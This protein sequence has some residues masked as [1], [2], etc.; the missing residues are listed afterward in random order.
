[1]FP[2]TRKLK[3]L[4]SHPK[5]AFFKYKT[6]AYFKIINAPGPYID[7]DYNR[8]WGFANF[9]GKKILDLGADY[10]STAWFFIKKGANSVVA[11][12]GDTSRAKTLAANSVKY[13]FTSIEEMITSPQSIEQ[14]LENYHFDIAKVDI[15][16]AEIHLL[17]CKRELLEK[18][19]LWMIECHSDEITRSLTAHF[20]ELGFRVKCVK[21]PDDPVILI[22][23]KTLSLQK[24]EK[25]DLN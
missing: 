11:I 18:V 19:S 6:R 3:T 24:N 16:G 4:L 21:S 25:V 5:K 23:E 14:L 8:H 1:M 20:E 12:E 7:E 2:I 22:A 17:Q 13:G 9:K 10:G 15:E